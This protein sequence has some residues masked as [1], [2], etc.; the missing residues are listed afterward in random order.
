MVAVGPLARASRSLHLSR[1]V[2]I[3]LPEGWRPRL[4]AS[5]PLRV[6]LV[7]FAGWRSRLA[8]ADSSRTR[9]I[10]LPDGVRSS[11]LTSVRTCRR[12]P[13]APGTFPHIYTLI[14]LSPLSAALVAPS[15][16]LAAVHTSDGSCVTQKRSSHEASP[17]MGGAATGFAQPSSDESILSSAPHARAVALRHR[18]LDGSAFRRQ[19]SACHWLPCRGLRPRPVPRLQQTAV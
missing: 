10:E 11:G 14:T 13:A 15:R 19:S 18:F 9:L 4:A 17:P 7:R 3:E 6:R 8:S 12:A 2:S 1:R 16:E 5:S